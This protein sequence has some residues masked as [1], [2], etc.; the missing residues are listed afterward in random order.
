MPTV[1]ATEASRR[2]VGAERVTWTK[3]Y[4]ARYAAGQSIRG[5]ARDTGRS[6]G[7]AHRLLVEGGATLRSWGGARR[8]RTK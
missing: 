4:L 6:Y 5:I 7:F 8:R 1:G 2:I 3:D